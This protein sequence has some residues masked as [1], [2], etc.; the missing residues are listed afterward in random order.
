MLPEE[1]VITNLLALNFDNFSNDQPD[2]A[3][4]LI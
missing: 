4:L 1:E 2:K 3:Y